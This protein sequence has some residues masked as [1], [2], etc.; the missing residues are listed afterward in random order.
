MIACGLALGSQ[1]AF[2]APVE[3]HYQ[4]GVCTHLDRWKN[5]EIPQM[6]ADAGITW[7][8]D[9]FYWRHMEQERGKYALP[10]NYQKVLDAAHAANL[11]VVAIFNGGNSN[12]K[13]DIYD[14]DAFARAAA[15]FA[16]ETTGKVH[17]IEIMNEPANFGYT[18]H[19]GGS[20]N[21]VDKNGNVEPWVQKY[22]VLLNKTAKAIKAANPNVRVIGLGSVPPVNFRQIA[23]GIAPEVDGITEHPYSFRLLPEYIPF[24]AS[25]G[26]LRRDGIATA[27]A[28]G[29]LA[30]Q[31]RMY[32]ELL[33]KHNGP[34]EKW[35]TEWGWPTYSE[36]KP[37]NIYAG[38]T[39]SA[40]AKYILRR[41]TQTLGL[42][43]TVTFIYDFRNDGNNPFEAE[44]NFGLVRADLS[45]KPSYHA[46][47]RFTAH[48][49]EF[50]PKTALPEVN[51]FPVYT[52]SDRQP[53]IWD[54][55]KIQGSGQVMTYQFSDPKGTPRIALWA[56]ERADGDL[57]PILGDVE[58]VCP[59]PV[60]KIERYDLMTGQVS[61]VQFKASGNRLT[62]SR[63]TIPD[64]PITLTL[65]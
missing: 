23:M 6:I 36:A 43:T 20:W 1:D 44:D 29:T 62:I 11:K 16:K 58:F 54:G 26:I 37:G 60:E 10:A 47:K 28:Q 8:R 55:S 5:D 49:A 22:V 2:P 18:K 39:E 30:S 19:Y 57:N 63:M 13:P 17:A 31:L 14:P 61:E 65:K 45:P 40:Q 34:K 38:F 9:D 25:D 3:N 12:Y 21:G 52:R 27:D 42:G 59:T 4:V 50:R 32:D 46:V 64:Y 41:L 56:C 33:K 7:I 51:V 48:M 53:I 35:L 24:A 15:W